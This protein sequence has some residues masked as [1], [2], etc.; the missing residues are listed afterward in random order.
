VAGSWSCCGRADREPAANNTTNMAVPIHVKNARQ[1]LAQ[2][3]LANTKSP[4]TCS[5]AVKAAGG[6]MTVTDKLRHTG[7]CQA[8]GEIRFGERTIRG[9]LSQEGKPTPRAGHFDGLPAEL[10][11]TKGQRMQHAWKRPTQECAPIGAKPTSRKWIDA[12][13]VGSENLF[14]ADGRDT[15]ECSDRWAKH[16]KWR[17][18]QCTTSCRPPDTRPILRPGLRPERASACQSAYAFPERK[19]PSKLPQRYSSAKRVLVNSM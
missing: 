4:N 14:G 11:P 18:P 10:Q 8:K 5:P 7:R 19:Y 13:T 6:Q 2:C 17:L 16:S 3:F 9:D 1:I 15:V 12:G